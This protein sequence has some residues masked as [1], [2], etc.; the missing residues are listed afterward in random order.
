MTIFYFTG[1]GN[2]LAVAKK[3]GGNLISIPKVVDG[4]NLHYKD[5]VIG[6]VFPIYVFTPPGMVSRF[7]EKAKLEADY[8]FA[9]GTYGNMALSTMSNLQKKM[10]TKDFDYLN[11]ILMV[12]NFLNIFEMNSQIAKIPKKKIDEKLSQIISDIQN[13]KRMDTNPSCICKDIFTSIITALPFNKNAPKYIVNDNCTK[14][15]ICTKVCPAHN[16]TVKDNVT[17]GNDCEKCYAC[18]HLCPQNAIHLKSERS[19]KR[20]RH[21]DVSLSEI[22]EANNRG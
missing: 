22:I 6:V 12:D 2:S 18:I 11:E 19:N 4:E 20:W 1:T 16:I 13:R 7:L 15:D 3:I 21:P 5:D 14:C 8:T 9:I 10:K 17:F